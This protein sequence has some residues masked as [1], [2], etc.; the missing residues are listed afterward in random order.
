MKKKHCLNNYYSNNNDD[1]D[2][3][4]RSNNNRRNDRQASKFVG[5][6][7]KTQTTYCVI[8]IMQLQKCNLTKSLNA[9]SDD[10]VIYRVL[11]TTG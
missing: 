6:K 8:V 4:S 3:D 2:D 10:R 11:R 9:Q 1:N 5:C 7:C